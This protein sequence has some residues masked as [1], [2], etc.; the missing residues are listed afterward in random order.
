MTVGRMG[1]SLGDHAKFKPAAPPPPWGWGDGA[2]GPG[3]KSAA[4]EKIYS[5]SCLSATSWHLRHF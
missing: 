1:G 3:P 4:R 5:Q 2:A